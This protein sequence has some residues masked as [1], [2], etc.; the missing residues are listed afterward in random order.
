MPSQISNQLE[1]QTA[2][3]SSSNLKA[4]GKWYCCL[5]PVNEACKAGFRSLK[6]YKQHRNAKHPSAASKL[7][8][9]PK[10]PFI[11]EV[12][13]VLPRASTSTSSMPSQ[14]H[15]NHEVPA[16]LGAHFAKHPI[17]NGVFIL[18]ASACVSATLN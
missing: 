14:D 4:N 16:N 12:P 5:D 10:Y 11:P 8:N 15:E 18:L 9:T 7:L 13:V 6:G 3:A 2:I 1:S 17:L